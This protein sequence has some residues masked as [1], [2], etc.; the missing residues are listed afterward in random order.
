MSTLSILAYQ[1]W[2]TAS[3]GLQGGR[4]KKIKSIFHGLVSEG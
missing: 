2:R 3:A 4:G 1:R